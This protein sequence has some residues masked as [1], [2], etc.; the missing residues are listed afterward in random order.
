MS[1]LS[2][3]LV[4]L[5]LLCTTAIV[6][7]P[8][9][10]ESEIADRV[11]ALLENTALP[12]GA[13]VEIAVGDPD[14]RL[15]LAPC[16]AYEP[17][18][19]AGAR[20][21]GRTSLGVRCTDGANWT[22]YL[23]TQIKVFAPALV[24]A[25]PLVRGQ[26]VL[27]DDVRLDRVELTA[28]P[29]GVLGAGDALEGRTVTR[30]LAAGEPLRRD[31]LRAPNVLQAGDLVRVQAGGAGYAITT[32]G[33]ALAAAVDGQSTQI[34]VGGKVLHGVARAGKVVEIK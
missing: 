31:L 4:V 12:G 29:A 30:A 23:P 16:R 3:R 15:Q 7:L 26:S 9:R 11:R 17:F 13:E 18:V 33:K 20:L 10:A 5:S 8:A 32:E 19:P 14:P 2:L 22:I 25:R 21:W 34:A 6:A 24:A 27:P 1:Q 28:H